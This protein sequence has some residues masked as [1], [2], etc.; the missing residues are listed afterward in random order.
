MTDREKLILL[1]AGGVVVGSYTSKKVS[2]EIAKRS[3]RSAEESWVYFRE[4]IYHQVWT[5][6]E[7]ESWLWQQWLDWADLPSGSEEKQ[8]W[9]QWAVDHVI[10]L[11]GAGEALARLSEQT[12][13]WLLSNHCVNWLH[14]GLEKA[15]LLPYFSQLFI[16]SEIGARKPQIEAYSQV[17]DSWSGRPEN[18]LYIDDKDEYLAPAARLGMNTLRSQDHPTEWLLV[19]ENF[20]LD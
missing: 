12:D 18:I 20:L 16:S 15:G 6:Q 9:S 13:I 14:P 1:D 10:P 3:D 5:G 8:R 17:L 4:H 2:D 19:A 11:A 7:N